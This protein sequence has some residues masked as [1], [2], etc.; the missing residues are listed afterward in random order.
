MLTG[1]LFYLKRLALTLSTD[2]FPVH[3]LLERTIVRAVAHYAPS[4][5]LLKL[6]GLQGLF[7]LLNLGPEL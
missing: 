1:V 2:A 3:L 6:L 4:Q 7:G 5:V